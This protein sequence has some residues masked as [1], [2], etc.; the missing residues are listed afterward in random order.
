MSIPRLI[1]LSLVFICAIHPVSAHTHREVVLGLLLLLGLLEAGRGVETAGTATEQLRAW[2]GRLVSLSVWPFHAAVLALAFLGLSAHEGPP[3]AKIVSSCATC[4]GAKSSGCGGSGGGGCGSPAG[5]GSSCGCSSRA[6]A[7]SAPAARAATPA[8]A[9]PKPRVTAPAPI[10]AVRVLP[11]SPG[12]ASSSKTEMSPM[13]QQATSGTPAPRPAPP[14][15]GNS[16]PVP[17]RAPVQS[18]ATQPPAPGIPSAPATATP[19]PTP[20]LPA[21]GPPN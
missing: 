19:K 15:Q 14:T 20:A 16:R 4:A 7:S 2:L 8:P 5:T 18:L 6:T 3:A 12:N 10:P 21:T 13:V 1:S 17:L 9:A 11:A